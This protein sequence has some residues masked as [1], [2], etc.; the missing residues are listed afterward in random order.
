V[1]EVWARA[2]ADVVDTFGR[3]EAFPDLRHRARV[4][5][6]DYVALVERTGLV[7]FP[8][9]AARTL[10]ELV[11][12]ILLPPVIVRLADGRATLQLVPGAEPCAAWFAAARDALGR[13][14]E[15]AAD[16]ASFTIV[17][18]P[19]I[20]PAELVL[21]WDAGGAPLAIVLPDGS[22]LERATAAWQLTPHQARVL[23]H[24]AGGAAN[25]EIAAALGCAENTVELHVTRLLRKAQVTSRGQL[26]ARYWGFPQ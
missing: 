18:R 7:V 2:V 5:W 22:R 26:I 21:G 14:G 16:R 6:V 25:K 17:E 4:R 1:H 13:G 15:V 19:A 11:L 12:P 8:A 9:Y 10:F 23:A 3:D 20:A 24:V